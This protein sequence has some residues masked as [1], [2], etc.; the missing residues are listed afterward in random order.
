M[1]QARVE[2]APTLL[3]AASAMECGCTPCLW[4]LFCFKLNL[5]K[6]MLIHGITKE[7]TEQ[8]QFHDAQEGPRLESNELPLYYSNSIDPL[9]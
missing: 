6:Y 9:N 5:C 1:A 3:Q 2:R 8:K 4:A 7:P